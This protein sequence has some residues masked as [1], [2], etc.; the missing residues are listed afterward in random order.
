MMSQDDIIM[1]RCH[2]GMAEEGMLM[3]WWHLEIPSLPILYIT[4]DGV[5]HGPPSLSH[6]LASPGGV[7]FVGPLL[8]LGPPGLVECVDVD[9]HG[10]GFAGLAVMLF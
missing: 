10:P 6:R 4:P 5:N 8:L 2:K 1:F 7:M 9:P 3:E